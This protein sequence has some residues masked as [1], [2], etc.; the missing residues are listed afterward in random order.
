MTPADHAAIVTGAASG[1]GAATARA[2]AASGA[3]VA[4]LD[5]SNRNRGASASLSCRR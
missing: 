5:E 1:L 2:L 3:R 4:L